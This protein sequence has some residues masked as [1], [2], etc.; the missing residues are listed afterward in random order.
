[1][2]LSACLFQHARTGR[3]HLRVHKM[4]HLSYKGRELGGLFGTSKRLH[5]VI[6]SLLCTHLHRRGGD[7]TCAHSTAS[8]SVLPLR[9]LSM[10]RPTVHTGALRTPPIVVE[11]ELD[12]WSPEG[13]GRERGSDQWAQPCVI[14]TPT[15]SSSSAPPPP[16]FQAAHSAVC[17]LHSQTHTPSRLPPSPAT[18]FTETVTSGQAGGFENVV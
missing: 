13:R 6:L 16:P 15:A 5:N 7:T 14:Y 9:T 4:T 10:C 18:R 11:G 2:W 3:P 8:R 1:M 12:P 17:Q